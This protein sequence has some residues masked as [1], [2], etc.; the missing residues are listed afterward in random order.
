MN[1]F[2]K[3]ISKTLAT[4]GLLT[5]L[6][7]IIVFHLLVLTQTIPYSIVWGGRLQD[8]SQMVVFEVISITLNL[9]MIAI[10]CIHAG[11]WK[12]S[13]S[14]AVLKIM[15]WG[16]AIL[17]MLNTIGNLFSLNELEKFLFTPL[18]LLLSIFSLRLAISRKKN[19][20]IKQ[21]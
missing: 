14:Q 7:L 17:F 16:M 12:V 4:R 2:R 9:L 10:V 8:S 21:V 20:S 11:I 15:L 13:V 3:T 1:S 5:I 6:S 18:T 19:H